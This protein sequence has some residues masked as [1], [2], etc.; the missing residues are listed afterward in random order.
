M[1]KLPAASIEGTGPLGLFIRFRHENFS[2]QNEIYSDGNYRVIETRLREVP[3]LRVAIKVYPT[4]DLDKPEEDIP[5]VMDEL[6]RLIQINPPKN[7]FIPYLG[8]FLQVNQLSVVRE[9][10]PGVIFSRII[11]GNSFS[12]DFIAKAALKLCDGVRH[13]ISQTFFNY[14]IK[15]DNLFLREDGEIC[16]CDFAMIELRTSLLRKGASSRRAN[17]AL[18]QPE[19]FSSGSYAEEKSDVYS[20]GLLVWMMAAKKIPKVR[21]FLPAEVKDP[22]LKDIVVKAM[23]QSPYERPDLAD[24]VAMINEAFPDAA[25]AQPPAEALELAKTA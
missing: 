20:I 14:S 3:D 21:R 25:S 24:L 10:M 1:A 9:Y 4:A 8:A 15:P 12:P 6:L 13:L 23:N 22:K 11:P 17:N 7:L 2:E 18:S 16:M 5:K 19:V